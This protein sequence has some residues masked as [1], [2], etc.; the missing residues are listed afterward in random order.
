MRVHWRWLWMSAVIVAG[1]RAQEEN[2]PVPPE[3][4]RQEGVPEGKLT[5]GQFTS[6]AIYP[7]TERDYWLYL[8]AQWQAGQELALM[9]F[10]DGRSFCQDNSGARAH[11]VFDTLIH[12]GEMP[13]TAGVFVNPGVV[14]AAGEDA[15]PRFNRSLEYDDI[16]DRY[17]R[18]LLEEL[19]PHIEKTHGV[20][21]SANPNWRGLC[22]ASSG[23]IC[24]FA[25][26]WNRPDAFRR[27]YSLI[28]TFVGLREGETLSTLVRKTEPK[29]LR[30]FLQDGE[31]DLNIYCGDWWMEN[32]TMQRALDWAGYPVQHA[33][34]TG[35]HNHK[36]GAAIFPQAMRWLWQDWREP[37]T[38]R[39]EAS[40]SRFKEI[41]GVGSAWERVMDGLA[42]TG[43]ATGADGTLYAV[44]PMARLLV[45][46]TPGANPAVWSKDTGGA[47][48]LALAADGRLLAACPATR[49]LRAWDA[50]TGASSVLAGNLPAQDVLGLHNGRVY[51]TGEKGELWTWAAGAGAQ[52]VGELPGAGPL[53]TSPDQSLLYVG[54]P[55]DRFVHS[56]Q[57]AADGKPR[58]G[59]PY[60]HLHLPG[61]ATRS[62]V[63]DLAV[64]AEGW[65]FAATDLGVQICDQPGRVN[66]ILPGPDPRPG[67]HAV[68]LH[69]QTLYVATETGVWKRSLRVN[70][71]PAHAA[72]V[73]PPKPG[74]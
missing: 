57:L 60:F 31:K 45:R 74:L 65:L 63:S 59:Q 6:P 32:Q 73:K 15:L 41:V 47:R 18:F 62:G 11:R 64:S 39:W 53:T 1:L 19:L 67:V 55:A 44:D 38:P 37:I 70:A 40:K 8:P 35:A 54:L 61:V 52:K 14:P 5:P 10:Q 12:S 29:P 66:L 25:A 2:Y 50:Q 49:E 71:A 58:F 51:L 4:K 34:G 9:V 30:L 42:P 43:L 36:H 69:G 72:P 24:A 33:W 21:F 68:H 13:L 27:V 3:A 23:G 26:A 20:R 7:G 22:G 17:A 16:S 46:Q 28:G 56:Y 48:R